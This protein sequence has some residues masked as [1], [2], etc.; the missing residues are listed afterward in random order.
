MKQENKAIII[1]SNIK[2]FR[3]INYVLPSE[4][5]ISVDTDFN[6]N[7]IKLQNIS[8]IC[9]IKKNINSFECFIYKRILFYFNYSNIAVLDCLNIIFRT[10]YIFE[11]VYFL[12]N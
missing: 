6:L 4:I 8:H 7:R 5:F 10:T 11:N 12:L 3:R 9:Y 1:A 2:K